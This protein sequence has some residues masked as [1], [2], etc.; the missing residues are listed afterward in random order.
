M[1]WFRCLCLLAAAALAGC[2]KPTAEE[3]FSRAQQQAQAA[4]T[5][6]DTL[7]SS[8]AVREAF[9]PALASFESVVRE[10]PHHPLAEPAL[11]EIANIKNANLHM[12]QEAIDGYARYCSEYPAGKQT[13]LA[14]FL[15]GY[16]YNNELH[17][18]DSAEAAYRRFL[19]KFPES[20]M[21]ASA[22]FELNTLGKSPEEA[23]PP[24]G[25]PAQ[26]P[27]KNRARKTPA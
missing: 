2:G 13:P 1:K 21:A 4:A 24:S 14:M 7:R 16:L 23:L 17:N 12:P 15:I 19:E 8:D 11:F 3:Y 20:E 18:T 22:R 10:Y 25:M 9:Q 6:A 27:A 5:M 26:D